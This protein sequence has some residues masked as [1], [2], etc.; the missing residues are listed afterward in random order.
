MKL[1]I[2]AFALAFGV[3]WGG[4][5]FLMTWWLLLTGA[6]SAVPMALDTFYV[7]YAITPVGSLVGL[8]YGFVCGAVCGAILAW[9]Y[10]VFAERLGANVAGATGH[11]A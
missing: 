10:N 1:N 4:G 3:W 11:T 2:G 8:A 6:S 9:L 5:I 7:G